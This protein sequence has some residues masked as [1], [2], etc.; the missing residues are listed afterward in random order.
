MD[1]KELLEF[2]AV[3]EA[4]KAGLNGASMLGLAVG[5]NQ[6][7]DAALKIIGDTRFRMSLDEYMEC[8]ASH[9]FKVVYEER[10]SYFDRYDKVERWETFYCLWDG[11]K[12]ITF[13]TYSR[14]KTLNGGHCYFSWKPEDRAD[15]PKGPCSHASDGNVFACS[16]DVREA[17]FYWLSKNAAAGEFVTPHVDGMTVWL[18]TFADFQPRDGTNDDRSYKVRRDEH[19]IKSRARAAKLPKEVFDNLVGEYIRES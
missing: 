4:E 5:H 14:G 2:D 17:L 3:C 15:W 10:F 7:V 19:I 9:G 13:D 11:S 18:L 12:L 8:F 1:L 6:R 16:I